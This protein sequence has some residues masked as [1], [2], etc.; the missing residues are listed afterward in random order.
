M[1]K[2]RY[3]RW[4]RSWWAIGQDK[5]DLGVVKEGGKAHIVPL[6]VRLDVELTHIPESCKAYVHL[7]TLLFVFS[8]Y[9]IKLNTVFAGCRW[10]DIK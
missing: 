4:T 3:W 5:D 8:S 6:E 9:L 7:T 10:M 1:G 2:P